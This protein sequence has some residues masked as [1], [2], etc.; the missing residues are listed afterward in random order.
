M[1]A[2]CGGAIVVSFETAGETPT[3]KVV[4][5]LRTRSISLNSE[6]VDVTNADSSGHWRE[7]LAGC[8]VRSASISGSGVFTGNEGFDEVQD[9]FMDRSVR[10]AKILIPGWGTFEG[11]FRVSSLEISGEYND[12]VQ[13]SMS[14]ESAGA[15]TFTAI[16]A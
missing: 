7:L 4:A 15:L 6:T 8:G 11:P 12:S 5:G 16:G 1:A 10:D 14:L 2:Q 3:Y 9:A 13:C